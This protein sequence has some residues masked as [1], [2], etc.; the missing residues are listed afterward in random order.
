MAAGQAS[1]V[2]FLVSTTTITLFFWYTYLQLV[3]IMPCTR[4]W[5]L[6]MKMTFVLHCPCSLVP[7]FDTMESQ[8][9]SKTSL[10]QMA[11]THL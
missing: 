7:E 2:A 10:S 8:F 3:T 1:A 9:L 4:M 6:V 11:S 5:N